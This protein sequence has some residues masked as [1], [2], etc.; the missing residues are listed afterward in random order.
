MFV[1]ERIFTSVDLKA[2]MPAEAIKFDAVDAVWRSIVST[3]VSDPRCTSVANI[4][5]VYAV[6]LWHRPTVPLLSPCDLSPRGFC[7]V[8]LFTLQVCWSA[9]GMPMRPW[10]RWTRAC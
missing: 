4:P 3:A 8:S 9:C 2:Q 7:C 1:S 6:K 5:G 10:R